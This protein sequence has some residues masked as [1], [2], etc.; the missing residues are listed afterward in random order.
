MSKVGR[1]NGTM[2]IFGEANELMA[3]LS[4]LMHLMQTAIGSAAGFFSIQRFTE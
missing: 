3:P 1:A 2:E 4:H